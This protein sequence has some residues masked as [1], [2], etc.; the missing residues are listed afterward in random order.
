MCII[1]L[2]S[3]LHNGRYY[4]YTSYTGVSLCEIVDITIEA[5]PDSTDAH[6][7]LFEELTF[8]SVT[9]KIPLDCFIRKENTFILIPETLFASNPEVYLPMEISLSFHSKFTMKFKPKFQY[10]ENKLSLECFYYEIE[11]FDWDFR[12]YSMQCYKIIDSNICLWKCEQDFNFLSNILHLD[13][14]DNIISFLQKESPY[15]FLYNNSSPSK[16]KHYILKKRR[17]VIIVNHGN[18]TRYDDEAT[19][20]ITDLIK[21]GQK[22][23]I[24]NKFNYAT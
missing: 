3:H 6:Y 4:V 21:L 9:F 12:P 16:Q 13:V 14:V 1:S 15:M 11:S 23:V 7:V 5:I 8:T 10:H 20:S 24:S 19:I 17:V 22:A 2:N 18:T